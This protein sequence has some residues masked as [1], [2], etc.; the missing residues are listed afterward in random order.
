MSERL[1]PEQLSGHI[2]FM[3]IRVVAHD[4]FT[5]IMFLGYE[6]VGIDNKIL[7]LC[8]IYIY[9]FITARLASIQKIQKYKKYLNYKHYKGQVRIFMQLLP[10][11]IRHLLLT[12]C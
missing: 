1:F 11:H 2:G 10:V 8:G 7:L 6:N 4:D 12:G 5:C 3:V 9:V